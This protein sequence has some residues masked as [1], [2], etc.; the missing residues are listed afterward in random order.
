MAK[1]KLALPNVDRSCIIVK[2][3][4]IHGKG[5]FAAKPIK[6]G[7]AIIE[8]KGERISWKLAI[9]RHPHDKKD[10]NHTFYF[11]IDDDRVIDALHGGNSARWINHSCSPN[12]KPVVEDARVFIKAK[13]NIAAGEELNYDYGLIIDEPYT[14]KL[15]AEYP[16][17]C[18]SPNCRKTLLAPKR[19]PSTPKIPSQ[20][21]KIEK[22]IKKLK[23]ELKAVKKKATTSADA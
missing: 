11:Q 22:K 9:K 7:Q 23:K 5:V 20:I 14:P 16:C 21:K 17:W 3:S 18:G 2:S 4:P 8:Y 15:K 6:K 12:C 19:R 13:R 1:K 10:P